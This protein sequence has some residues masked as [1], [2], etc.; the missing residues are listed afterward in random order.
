[1]MCNTAAK[2]ATTNFARI[3][4]SIFLHCLLGFSYFTWRS[5]APKIRR[6][7]S[8]RPIRIFWFGLAFVLLNY[9]QI[10]GTVVPT[11]VKVTAKAVGI[12]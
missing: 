5:A 6:L 10:V 11:G 2:H 1:M 4:E 9:D 8:A 3:I 7:A 12:L